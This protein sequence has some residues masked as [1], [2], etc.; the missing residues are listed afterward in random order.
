MKENEDGF[1]VCEKCNSIN[2]DIIN[3]NKKENNMDRIINNSCYLRLSYF[4]KIIN[5]LNG[6][7][8]MK[9]IPEVIQ[10]IKNRIEIEKL[11]NIRLKTYLKN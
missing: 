3:E 9:I 4:K 2:T 1:F 5:Q 11:K 6:R 8:T 10:L 7:A